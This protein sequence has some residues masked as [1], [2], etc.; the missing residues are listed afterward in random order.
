[1]NLFFSQVYPGPRWILGKCE[2]LNL[3]YQNGYNS[4]MVHEAYQ[5]ITKAQKK[6]EVQEME[7]VD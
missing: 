1:M 3:G 5:Y 6:I 2:F 4:R 7:E